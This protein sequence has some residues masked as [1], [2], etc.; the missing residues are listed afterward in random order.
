MP[1]YQF[2]CR[3]CGLFDRSYRMAEVPAHVACPR[4]AQAAVRRPG[5]GLVRRSAA[6]RMLDATA[7]TAS[8]PAVVGAV[9]QPRT[10]RPTTA[11]LRHRRL[12]RP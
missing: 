12:P 4:C 10:S 11:D 3:G 1:L 9:P 8:E 7:R 2:S 5:G 6:V